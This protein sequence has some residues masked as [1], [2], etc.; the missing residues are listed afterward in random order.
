MHPHFLPKLIVFSKM[1]LQAEKANLHHEDPSN[2]NLAVL[3]RQFFFSFCGFQQK[4][5]PS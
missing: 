1:S 3:H 4:I 5:G 2:I